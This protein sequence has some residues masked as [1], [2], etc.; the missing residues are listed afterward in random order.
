MNYN[1]VF[2]FILYP[3]A[4]IHIYHRYIVLC[5]GE[6]PAEAGRFVLYTRVVR[7]IIIFNII[8]TGRSTIIRV[9]YRRGVLR[10]KVQAFEDDEKREKLRLFI[11]LYVLLHVRMYT[12]YVAPV[13]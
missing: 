1:N 8:R 3:H 2:V 5:A 4:Y 11:L 6:K 7:L 12:Y 10:E 9:I 13:L